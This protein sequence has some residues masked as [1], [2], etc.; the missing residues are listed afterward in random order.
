MECQQVAIYRAAFDLKLQGRIP[1]EVVH[2]YCNAYPGGAEC[3][4]HVIGL[5]QRANG[6]PAV[7]IH[8]VHRLDSQLYA[9]RLRLWQDGGNAFVDLLT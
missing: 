2:I 6:G 3:N 9:C 8:R 4:G 5:G 1:P 7:C